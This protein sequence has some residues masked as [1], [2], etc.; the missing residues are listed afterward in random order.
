MLLILLHWVM[1]NKKFF[2]SLQKTP[3]KLPVGASK[4]FY[5]KMLNVWILYTTQFDFY[6]SSSFPTG[7]GIHVSLLTENL[8]L[9]AF[10]DSREYVSEDWN[11][12]QYP[13]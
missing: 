4:S 7:F 9:T 13:V 10:R 5:F 3:S 12:F 2:K 1:I 6:L 8:A 11:I